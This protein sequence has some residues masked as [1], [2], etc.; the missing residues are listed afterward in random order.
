[1]TALVP[2]PTLFART[3]IIKASSPK[4]DPAI[5]TSRDPALTK[6]YLEPEEF[7]AA[8]RR[9]LTRQNI[10]ATADLPA[11]PRNRPLTGQPCRQ[12]LR[13]HGKTIVGFSVIIQ[14][15]TAEES[16]RIQE[17]GLGGRA[18]MGCGFFMPFW[19]KG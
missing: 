5:K 14:G 3:V 12:V 8:I 13:I 19:V 4:T 1:M 16:I 6:R 18:K 10:A 2:A 15:L 11:P 7:L 17:G 9:E